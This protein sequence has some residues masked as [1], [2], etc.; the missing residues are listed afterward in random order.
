MAIWAPAKKDTLE[1][2]GA[3]IVHN[4]GV[5]RAIVAIDGRHDSGTAAFADDLAAALRITGHNMFR[6]SL[7]N[8]PTPLT[9]FEP[10]DLSTPSAYYAKA[11]D[12]SV[13]NRVLIDPFRAS[14]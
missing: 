10:A 9:Q 12:Y 11:F 1:S 4:Y 6:A 7:A 3:E 8:F 2:L 13:L 14:G 5:G